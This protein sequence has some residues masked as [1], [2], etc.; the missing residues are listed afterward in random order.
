MSLVKI[1]KALFLLSIVIATGCSFTSSQK[2]QSDLYPDS[3]F[4][5]H[6]KKMILDDSLNLDYS[7]ESMSFKL[8]KL[9][10]KDRI[11]LTDTVL[12]HGSLYGAYFYSKQNKLKELLPILVLA[13]ADDYQSVILFIISNERKVTGYMQLT[14]DACD[15]LTQTEDKEIVGCHQRDSQFLNDST[16][17]VTDLE[18]VIDGYGKEDAIT[19]T[20]SVT[21]DYR[22]TS[23]GLINQMQKDSVRIIK[24]SNR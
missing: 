12:G 23:L 14:A 11:F 7:K 3:L 8:H 4:K 1:F 18:I 6:S 15:V 5:Y 22:I 13:N 16:F 20:D 21:L 19:T 17:R 9:S 24:K 10:D 2:V